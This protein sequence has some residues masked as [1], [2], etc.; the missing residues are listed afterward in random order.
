[1]FD[2]ERLK[3]SKMKEFKKVG[4]KEFNKFI[5]EYPTKLQRDVTGIS[6][7]PLVTYNDFSNGKVWPESIVARY[8]LI[9]E[10]GGSPEF[11]IAKET[12]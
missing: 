7:P 1:M 3:L 12:V 5:E 2:V 6:D 4:K 9:D 10:R 11:K 8:Y